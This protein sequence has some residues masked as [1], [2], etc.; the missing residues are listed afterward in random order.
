[1]SLASPFNIL[2]VRW[3]DDVWIEV[4]LVKK[5]NGVMYLYSVILLL[6]IFGFYTCGSY[7]NQFQKALFSFSLESNAIYSHLVRFCESQPYLLTGDSW[8]TLAIKQFKIVKMIKS[9]SF[10]VLAATV[11][12]TQTIVTVMK[13]KIRHDNF[14]ATG[15]III[16]IWKMQFYCII[17]LHFLFVSGLEVSSYLCV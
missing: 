16:L 5:K 17:T 13:L 10:S 1:M 9:K 6:T 2:W 8:I 7:N 14:H 11:N 4:D 12:N 15:N 3:Q